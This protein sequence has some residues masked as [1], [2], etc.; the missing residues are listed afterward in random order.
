MTRYSRVGR[1][2]A[3]S[4]GCSERALSGR[5]D[6][7]FVLVL[8]PTK[9]HRWT[10]LF[11]AMPGLAGEIRD[12]MHRESEWYRLT[13]V[14]LCVCAEELLGGGKVKGSCG[15]TKVAGLAPACVQLHHSTKSRGTEVQ[16]DRYSFSD[17]LTIRKST[18]CHRPIV[19]CTYT[20]TTTSRTC[21]ITCVCLVLLAALLY[22]RYFLLKYLNRSAG[23]N[24]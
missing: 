23:S 6:G 22:S 19:T 7:H 1:H 16:C 9:A 8:W 21:L 5:R 17:S 14:R 4:T 11:P 10:H 18:K 2:G 24:F 12:F 15:P 3:S 13:G 20:V